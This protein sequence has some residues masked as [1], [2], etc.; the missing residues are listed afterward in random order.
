[1]IL[2]MPFTKA[3]FGAG[4]QHQA[5]VGFF[6]KSDLAGI[7]YNQTRSPHHRLPDLNA[8]HRMSLFG[9]GSH[10]QDHIHIRSN[11]RYNFTL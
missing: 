1:M 2:I 7:N 3:T 4:L 10:Q 5:Q 8:D 6:R 11:V 9:V